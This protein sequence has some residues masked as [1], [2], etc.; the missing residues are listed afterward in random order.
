MKLFLSTLE[1]MTSPG[2]DPGEEI[3]LDKAMEVI[4]RLDDGQT[5][6][7]SVNKSNPS[8]GFEVRTKDSKMLVEMC[9][10][11]M[12][13]IHECSPIVLFKRLENEGR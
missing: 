3:N 10:G 1:T 12:V 8:S 9:A 7:I 2:V 5:L 4:L 6:I 13:H 11:N